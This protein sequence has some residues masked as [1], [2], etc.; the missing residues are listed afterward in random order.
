[1]V[2]VGDVVGDAHDV[3][4]QRVARLTGRVVQDADARLVAEVQSAPVALEPVHHAQTLLI[5]A[6]AAGVDLVE[7]PLA[8]VTERRV[9]EVVAET[10]R[11]REIL[12]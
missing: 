2:H 3:R 12:V 8:R 1:M 5:V 9:A 4:L 11:L 7:R 10:D 6:K